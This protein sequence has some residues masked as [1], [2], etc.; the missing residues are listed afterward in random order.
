MADP[1][2]FRSRQYSLDERRTCIHI[3]LHIMSAKN[4]ETLEIFLQGFFNEF[5][6]ELYW[7][8]E[9]MKSNNGLIDNV[10]CFELRDE[11]V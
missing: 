1:V 6:E 3:L 5:N 10:S 7:F 9:K 2:S 4:L 11:C 8:E